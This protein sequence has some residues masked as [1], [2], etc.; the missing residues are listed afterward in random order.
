[1]DHCDSVSDLMHAK[2]GQDI[3]V[4][5][6][7]RIL[8]TSPFEVMLIA[9]ATIVVVIIAIFLSKKKRGQVSIMATLTQVKEITHDTKIYTFE[10][11]SGM[12]RVGLNIGEHLELE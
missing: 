5:T 3:G 11:P 4:S 8:E 12:D 10:L 7:C 6:I 2:L 9:A 1:M